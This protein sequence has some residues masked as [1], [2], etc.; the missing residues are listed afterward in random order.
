MPADTGVLVFGAIALFADATLAVIVLLQGRQRGENAFAWALLTLVVPFLGYGL[1]RL[2]VS[3]AEN[4]SAHD[5]FRKFM[6][7]GRTRRGRSDR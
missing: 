4:E 3:A 7:G 1:W 2:W 6:S 5:D